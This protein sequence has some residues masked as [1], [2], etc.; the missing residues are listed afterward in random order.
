MK[1]LILPGSYWDPQIFDVETQLFESE[2]WIFAGLTSDLQNHNDFV[3]VT[4]GRQP[5]VVQNFQGDLRAFKNVCT[6]RFSQIQTTPKGNR[7]LVCPYHGWN[8]D[9]TGKPIGIPSKPHFGTIDEA[10]LKQL[11][12]TPWQ[13]DSVGKFVFV[14]SSESGASLREFLGS[15]TKV[16]E[17]ISPGIGQEIDRNDLELGCNW[18]I[19]VENTLESYH[20]A[21]VHQNTFLR[22]GTS[23]QEFLFEGPHSSWQTG[24]NAKTQDMWEK[25]SHLYETRK[26]RQSGYFHQFIFPNLTIATT[27]GNSFSVQRFEPMAVDRTQFISWV[28]DT[29]LELHKPVEKAI[30]ASMNQSITAFN[31]AVFL[32][33][34]TVCAHVQSGVRHAQGEGLLSDIEGRVFA[35]Q[36]AYQAVRMGSHVSAR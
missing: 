22:L 3:T 17:A 19:A 6:H 35:F 28:Y 11:C 21:A 36:E 2:M 30:V 13:V 4:V 12:L 31:R 23:G 8:F 33:D 16:L 29:P 7:P 20:V 32:E 25:V 14:N 1:P 24:V 15:T 18:K 10:T 5:V 34:K 27:F 26:Y 9:H